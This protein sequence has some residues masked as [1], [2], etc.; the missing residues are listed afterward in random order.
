MVRRA[1]ATRLGELGKVVEVEFL[2]QDLVPVLSQLVQDEQD[3][4]RCLAVDALADMAQLL[5]SSDMEPH[6]MPSVRATLEDKSWRVRLKAAERI[7][8]VSISSLWFV[9]I[10]SFL[11]SEFFLKPNVYTPFSF[12]AVS[13]LSS[14]GMSCCRSSRTC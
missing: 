11:S 2:R 14:R 5:S 9:S 8:D 3:S 12:N 4:V 10:K 13:G 1:A 7:I 6:V